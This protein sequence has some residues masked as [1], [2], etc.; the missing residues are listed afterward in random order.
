[1]SLDEAKAE[2]A[3]WQ[4]NTEISDLNIRPVLDDNGVQIMRPA[5]Y[6]DYFPTPYPNDK[7]AAAA[8]SGIVLKNY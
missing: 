2:A 5:N 1:M 6:N 4:V 7:A 3:T 8:N